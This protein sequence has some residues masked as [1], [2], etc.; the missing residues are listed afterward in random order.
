MAAAQT[1]QDDAGSGH[2]PSGK[3]PALAPADQAV[4][5]AFFDRALDALEDG[6]EPDIESAAAG[7]E[8]LRPALERHGDLARAVSGRA[9]ALAAPT[10]GGYT[11]IRELGR[12]GMGVV[13]LAR[14][15][16]LGR[17]V[18]LKVLLPHFAMSPTGRERFT[19]EAQAIAMLRHPAIVSVFDLIS[20]RK[21]GKETHG[22]TMEWVDGRSLG[23]VI[24]DLAKSTPK[25]QTPSEGALAAALGAGESGP[26]SMPLVGATDYVMYIALMGA[27]LARALQ[28]VHDAGLHHRD[29]KP[30]NILLRRGGGPMLSDFGLVASSEDHETGRWLEPSSSHSSRADHGPRTPRDLRVA[31]DFA[32]TA[33]YSAPEQLRGQTVGRRTDVYGLAGTLFHALA[34]RPPFAGA[35]A[36]AVLAQITTGPAPRVRD[37]NPAVSR[38]FERALLCA[39]SRNPADRHPTAADFAADLEA[40]AAGR[41]LPGDPVTVPARVRV[42]AVRHGWPIAVVVI[43]LLVVAAFALGV[44]VAGR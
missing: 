18:A 30:S 31:K 1:G 16:A 11:I 14:H 27:T 3:E 2:G 15:A 4:V 24:Q 13:Y 42:W 5:E 38:D 35:D 12:G 44:F 34:L 43:L 6:R 40:V 17:D 7:R 23:E 29:L 22:F 25:G 20:D 26:A 37:F 28:A 9:D 39:M 21:E 8:H 10:F 36:A 19:R 41:P 33:T 32:G